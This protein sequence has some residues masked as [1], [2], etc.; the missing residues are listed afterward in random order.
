VTLGV[1]NST[2]SADQGTRQTELNKYIEETANT[3]QLESR[4]PPR[5]LKTGHIRG[6]EAREPLQCE[7]YSHFPRCRDEASILSNI[8]F[9]LQLAWEE[10]FNIL[11]MKL[12]HC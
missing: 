12:P 10:S 2:P 9:G 1:P 6:P 5:T 3:E 7:R 11:F 4:P 8:H